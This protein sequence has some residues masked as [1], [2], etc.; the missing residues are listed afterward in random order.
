MPE[1]RCRGTRATLL[2]FSVMRVEQIAYILFTITNLMSMCKDLA[3]LASSAAGSC[4]KGNELRT[5]A[6][7]PQNENL[8]T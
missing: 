2:G 6:A 1:K 3:M 5:A 4:S 7:F 8:L